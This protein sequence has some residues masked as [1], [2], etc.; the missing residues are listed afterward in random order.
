MKHLIRAAL[1][2]RVLPNLI[3][4]ALI[5]GGL[6]SL[7][8]INVRT[9]PEIATGTV[10]VGVTV[11]GAS[12]QDI[13]DSVVVP[14]EE[15]LSGLPDIDTITATATQ[16]RANISVG[17]RRGAEVRPAVNDIESEI[18]RI[19]VFPEDAE[20]PTIAEVEPD[21]LAIQI[22]LSGD[23]DIETLKSRAEEVRDDLLALDEVSQ[24]ELLGAP[25]D[26]IVIEVSE[27]TLLGYGISLP[28]LADRIRAEDVDLSAGQIETADEQIQIRADRERTTPADLRAVRLFASETGSTV[29]LGEIARVYETF[30]DSA[31]L[32]SR[33]DGRPAVYLAVNRVGDQQI[34]SQVEAVDEYLEGTL[35][36]SLPDAI[37]A[38]VWRNEAELLQSRIDLLTKNAAIG[39]GLITL[40]L[41]LFLD[42]RVAVFVAV[43]VGAAF[44]GSFVPMSV[45]GIT[46]NQLS[47]FGFILALGI[48]VDDAIV[49]G[50]AVYTEQESESDPFA[51]SRTASS[52]MAAPVFFSVSTTIAAFVPLLF[53][54]GSSG[55]FIAPIASVVIIALAL[56][57]L[58]SFF[59]LPQ[60][61]SGIRPGPPRHWWSPRRATEP[62]RRLVGGG[63]ERFSNGPLRRI[64]GF[65]AG[66]PWLP[67]AFSMSLLALSIGLIAGGW[68][69]VTFFPQI[70]G[71]FVTAE[72]EL[73]ESA[74]EAETLET[75]EEI[76]AAT[77][78]AAEALAERFPSPAEEIVAGTAVAIGFST[79]QG[80][81]GGG[82]TP[83]ARN[84]AT[85]TVKL[86]EAS[87]REFAASDF[88]R[89]WQEATGEVPGL[90]T[91]SFSSSLVGV[92]S[93]IAL[94]VSAE[95]DA[96]ADRAVGRLRDA[97]EGREGVYS[98]SDDRFS[99]A[100]EIA[101]T[102]K[103]E[104]QALGVSAD[105]V[106]SQLRA[107]FFGQTVTTLQR[108][109]EEVDVRIRLP[110][111]QR[112]SVAD[113][114]DLRIRVGD[115]FVPVTTVADLGF[116][117]APTVV[118]RA[119][120][121]TIVTLTADV[122]T[123]VTT[124]GAETGWLMQT[125]V[126]DLREQTPGLMV[127]VGGE[128][129]ERG[130]T[131]PALARN[132][133]LAMIAVYGILA[134]AFQSYFRPLLILMTVPFGL[135]G[136]VGGHFLLGLSLT[137]LSMFGIIGLAGIIVNG[138]LLI[139]DVVQELEAEGVPPE[140]AIVEA[141][142]RR[143][144]PILLTTLTTFF[145]IFPL[146]LETSVQ[147][148][149]L[150]PTAV[151]LAFGLLVAMVLLPLL[152]PAYLSV[153]NW[154]RR[155]VGRRDDR[156]R[157]AA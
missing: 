114:Q 57:L 11:P 19:T 3:F 144:R 8:S 36:P 121:R 91:L 115:G 28:E 122:D 83:G 93:P 1:A 103:P 27:E 64:V 59:V 79:G 54:P 12:P 119:E 18:D 96:L 147:A 45:F 20:S 80:G 63:V 157:S 132:F 78:A 62:L 117:Q 131:G 2:N 146:I 128:Q 68:V 138:G 98:I 104:A 37:S 92:G 35:R 134:L 139:N 25:T 94:E 100:R 135:I 76:A 66:H 110:E 42:L 55:S 125:V 7:S 73:P 29:E 127:S 23:T 130:Q 34:L 113:L 53:L 149:F 87:A 67:I 70:E 41:T 97:L 84:V 129:E 14:V 39:F 105:M 82:G 58:E 26:Q 33:L 116:R 86:A 52:R 38:T 60:H 43:G 137:L 5:V 17:L 88:E 153:Y 69:K 13:A 112:D 95:T 6:L 89:A 21:E 30:D 16:G 10:Q 151:S 74:S 48:V 46:I 106:A 133:G 118:R 145:G 155:R 65:C 141:T 22:V 85:I 49:V 90:K 150:I 24:V 56:S 81:P 9:F 44:V 126:P 51:A 152:M 107:A 109:R 143:F 123:S 154:A 124:G 156:A 148:K 61:L 47:L 15:A 75:A 120:G 99:T 4:A 77:G 140:D 32:V 136:A 142:V 72:V 71:N 108:D 101:V 50:E 40:I 31:A 111:S 102:M